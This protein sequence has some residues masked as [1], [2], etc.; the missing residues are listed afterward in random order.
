M[1]DFAIIVILSILWVVIGCGLLT[2]YVAGE[3]G[4]SSIAWFFCGLLFGPLG[5]I[6]IAGIPSA[7]MATS[8]RLDYARKLNAAD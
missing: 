6:A 8:E 3:K 1:Q 7:Q 5:L 4:R 2:A